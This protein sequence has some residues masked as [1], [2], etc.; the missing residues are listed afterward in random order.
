MS[1]TSFL[2]IVSGA[3]SLT[4]SFAADTHREGIRE[5]LVAGHNVRVEKHLFEEKEWEMSVKVKRDL[6]MAQGRKED[7]INIS[8]GPT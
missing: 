2:Q 3:S 7:L 1:S 6:R 4:T 5:E 8:S